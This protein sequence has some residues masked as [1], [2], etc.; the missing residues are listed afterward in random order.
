[1]IREGILLKELSLNDVGNFQSKLLI[2]RKGVLSDQLHN[3]IQLH[4][5][6]QDFLDALPQIGEL[7][8]VVF[9]EVLI[10]LPLVVGGRQSPVD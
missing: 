10:Q 5:L 2:L 8:V 4:L 3:F 1:M 6:V 7:F 9:V